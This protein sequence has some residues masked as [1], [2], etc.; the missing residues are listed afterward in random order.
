MGQILTVH[1]EEYP[2]RKIGVKLHFSKTAVHNATK[3]FLSH[4]TFGKI[5]EVGIQWKRVSEVTT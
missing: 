2:E 4:G 1:N 5:A 3:Y